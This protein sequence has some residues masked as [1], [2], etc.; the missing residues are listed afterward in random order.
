MTDL[1]TDYDPFATIYNQHW[2]DFA[3]RALPKLEKYVLNDLPENARILDL[4]CGTGQLARLLSKKGFAV[5]GADSSEEMLRYARQN[6]PDCVFLQADARAFDVGTGFDAVLS[7]F[8]SLNHIMAIEE[9]AAVFQNVHRALKN[10]GVF[11]FDLNMQDGYLERWRG[12][13]GIVEVDHA[14]IVRSSYDSEEKVGRTD[15]TMF[16]PSKGERPQWERSDLVLNQRCYEEKEVIAALESAG[17]SQITT[18]EPLEI[19]RMFFR[20][21]KILMGRQPVRPNVFNTFL[22]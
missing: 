4:C 15:I 5:L 3:A 19:G 22:L 17:F 18:H 20:S 11:V 7:T 16:F 13:F 14:V 21:M 12:S 10:G 9:L 1:Y 6:A 2:G 8:D